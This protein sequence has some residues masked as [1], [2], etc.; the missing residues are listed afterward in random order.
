MTT[1]HR[2]YKY[3][4]NK[5]IS[6]RFAERNFSIKEPSAKS[7]KSVSLKYWPP[8]DM[9][10]RLKAICHFF[11]WFVVLTSVKSP[12]Y[13]HFANSHRETDFSQGGLITE[14]NPCQ[15]WPRGTFSKGDTYLHDMPSKGLECDSWRWKF[16]NVEVSTYHG[17]AIY[18]MCHYH[19]V[20]WNTGSTERPI[21]YMEKDEQYWI[22]TPKILLLLNIY[23]D[24][25]GVCHW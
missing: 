22:T 25:N 23:N 9:S 5:F 21:Y 15:I 13:L 12:V 8:C 16:M 18:S 19:S 17:N 20:S 1:R 4:N 10:L 7:T 11:Q 6:P 2:L 14:S 24:W 3:T